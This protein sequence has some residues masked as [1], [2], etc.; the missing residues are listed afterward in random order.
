M[1]VIPCEGRGGERRKRKEKRKKEKKKEK[2]ERRHDS[3]INP[4]QKK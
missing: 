1:A 2:K 4:T 3:T